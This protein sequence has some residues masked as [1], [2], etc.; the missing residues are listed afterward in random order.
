MFVKLLCLI[1][2]RFQIYIRKMS[3]DVALLEQGD[4]ACIAW[5]VVRNV[6]C[7]H[8]DHICLV[9]IV[10]GNGN[11]VHNMLDRRVDDFKGFKRKVG[12]AIRGKVL[13]GFNLSKFLRLLGLDH[14]LRKTRDFVYFG[15]FMKKFW[16]I[17]SRPSL[18]EIALEMLRV[19]MGMKQGTI[20]CAMIVLD[21]WNLIQAYDNSKESGK[22]HVARVLIHASRDVLGLFF[23]KVNYIR[24]SGRY[25]TGIGVT[26]LTEDYYE[27]IVSINFFDVD[28]LGKVFDQMIKEL[29]EDQPTLRI[30]LHNTM[31][32]HVL[33]RSSVF[34][35]LYKISISVFPMQAPGSAEHVVLLTGCRQGLVKTMEMIMKMLLQLEKD[36]SNQ[37]YTNYEDFYDAA[38]A[39]SALVDKYGGFGKRILPPTPRQGKKYTVQVPRKTVSY[40]TS[41]GL[42]KLY[43][44]LTPSQSF[45]CVKAKLDPQLPAS[46]STQCSLALSSS[47][48]GRPIFPVEPSPVVVDVITLALNKDVIEL[49]SSNSIKHI[50]RQTVDQGED[51]EDMQLSPQEACQGST[52][53]DCEEAKDVELPSSVEITLSKIMA[54]LLAQHMDSIS[55]LGAAV[56]VGKV[57]KELEVVVSIS[58]SKDQVGQTYRR[59]QGVVETTDSGL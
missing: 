42:T 36:S 3:Y 22:V 8:F 14:P 41:N 6:H 12:L 23:S 9:S 28:D 37:F 46:G 1:K 7:R 55:R 39:D 27:R 40:Q 25:P 11:S 5:S 48:P 57:N 54:E 26:R 38:N 50:V 31:I 43:K 2:T 32:K 16:T 52:K 47:L 33:G 13:V 10:D 4:I 17:K 30:L 19:T 53:Y 58:G 56:K 44:N 59:I 51:V 35:S 15:P 24:K 20:K 21:L 45:E 18:G 29:G 34:L 49:E